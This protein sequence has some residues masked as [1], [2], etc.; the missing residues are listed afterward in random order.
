MGHPLLPVLEIVVAAV[1]EDM[2]VTEVVELIIMMVEVVEAIEVVHMVVIKEEMRVG[3]GKFLRL[4]PHLMVRLVA[5]TH[6]LR[7]LT[8][9]TLIMEQMQFLHLQAILVGLIHIPHHMVPL[10]VME[11]ML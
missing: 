4:H 9:G 8:E 11:V 5:V 6:H 3:M 2:V 7:T 1:I 10:L